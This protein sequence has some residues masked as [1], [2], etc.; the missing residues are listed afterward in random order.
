MEQN[1]DVTSAN[2]PSFQIPKW[3]LRYVSTLQFFNFNWAATEVRKRFFTPIPFS[4]PDRER[5]FVEEA[6]RENLQ[7]DGKQITLRTLGNGD[8]TAVFIH[9]WSGR[10]SQAYALA[11]ALVKA[12]YKVVTITAQA[13][14]NNPGKRT[15]MLQFTDAIMATAEHIGTVDVLIAHSIGGAA[16]FNALDQG[17]NVK[18]LVILGAP[19]SIAD[20]ISDFCDRLHLDHRYNQ[21]LEQYLND[22]YSPDIEAMA[23]RHLA[24]KMTV[25][26]LIV[27][28]K[29]DIDV[30]YEQ[31]EALHE[32]W[33]G[34]KLILTEGLGHRRILSDDKVIASILD[35]VD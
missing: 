34:S 33:K 4:L 27:H 19:S 14:G 13:H 26:G 30:H 11:P 2:T 24:K 6:E 31:A 22:N 29:Q 20:V 17:L 16:A 12:G 18:K 15:H 5:P 28:D 21:Y 1:K 9:G 7:V 10:G 23:P 25:Q 8:K 32:N 35:F 3:Y